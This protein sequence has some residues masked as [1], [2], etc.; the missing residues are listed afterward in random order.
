[1]NTRRGQY[2]GGCEYEYPPDASDHLQNI[3]PLAVSY[4]DLLQ[5]PPMRGVH[6]SKVQYVRHFTERHLQ[7]I[8]YNPELRPAQLKTTSGE[9]VTVEHSGTWIFNL[10][11]I[12][13]CAA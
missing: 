5:Q 6:E 11:R 9:T 3:L 13:G 12:F 10:A 4:L 7:C 2:E 1:M 8:W